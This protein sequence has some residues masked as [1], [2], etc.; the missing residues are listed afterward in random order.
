MT[1]INTIMILGGTHAEHMPVVKSKP[2]ER[3]RKRGFPGSYF[4]CQLLISII[5]NQ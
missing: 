3:F 2:V 4:F 1:A 5:I